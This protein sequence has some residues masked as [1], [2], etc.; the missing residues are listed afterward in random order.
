MFG[1]GGQL[2]ANSISVAPLE[3]FFLTASQE[4]RDF[5]CH[6]PSFRSSSPD[7]PPPEGLSRGLYPADT[8]TLS[9]S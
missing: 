1:S 7:S 2:G 8:G 4:G 6:P 5:L 3:L 9:G